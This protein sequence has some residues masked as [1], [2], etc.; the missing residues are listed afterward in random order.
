LAEARDLR[1]Q[2]RRAVRSGKDPLQERKKEKITAQL[3]AGN[4]FQSVAEDFIE[5][6]FVGNGKAE[7]TIE[8]ARW[9][10]S[11][12][13]SAIGARPIADI[14]PAELLAALKT[15]ER[16]GKR[17]TAM[18][19]RAFVSRVFRH[20]VAMSLC[21]TDPA[22]LIG[23][24]LMSPIVKHRAAIL[25]PAGLRELLRAID[26]YGGGA[27]V[28][29]AM[30]LLPHV[31][32]RPSELRNAKW[33]E[34]DCEEADGYCE[35]ARRTYQ[36]PGPAE[37]RYRSISNRSGT[38]VQMRATYSYWVRPRSVLSLRA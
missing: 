1:D 7:A 3:S 18:R 19:T 12:L 21:K 38:S 15:I 31:F 9:F 26:E 24:A 36:T 33:D 35:P 17:E 20:G 34:V 6:K 23:D 5:V 25:D 28:K 27:I 16:A 10:L 14:E 11:Y 2:A 4:S 32:V 8:K 29:I 37:W 22:A 30:P 13:T